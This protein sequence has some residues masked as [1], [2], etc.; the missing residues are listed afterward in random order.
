M[1]TQFLHNYNIFNKFLLIVIAVAAFSIP[2]DLAQAAPYESGGSFK[3]EQQSSTKKKETDTLNM[4]QNEARMYREKGL[5]LQNAGDIASAMSLYQKAI[6]L[7]PTYALPYNDLGIIFES[8]GMLDRA[9]E[10]YVRAIK[11]DPKL[12]SA[13]TNLAML[14][15]NKRQLNKALNYWRK[16]FELGDPLDPWTRR[17]QQRV[18]DIQA[19]TGNSPYDPKEEQVIAMMKEMQDAEKKDKKTLSKYYFKKAKATYDKGDKVGAFKQAVDAMQLDPSNKDIKEFVDRVQ[20]TLL[21]Q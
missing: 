9:E 12:L 16:R 6:E 18:K 8:K 14:Y 3:K 4:L 20:G 19:I 2:F 21:A 1:S 17:A 10:S 5:E 11:I 7:D 15:E 13:Y